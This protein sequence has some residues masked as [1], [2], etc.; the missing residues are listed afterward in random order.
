[1]QGSVVFKGRGGK[2]RH[3]RDVTHRQSPKSSSKKAYESH[4][5]EPIRSGY[6]RSQL[7]TSASQNAS[8]GCSQKSLM[9]QEEK[10]KHQK[11]VKVISV[12]LVPREETVRDGSGRSR[13]MFV[14]KR[15]VWLQPVDLVAIGNFAQ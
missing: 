10:K 5:H 9:V 7:G 15:C 14:A 8:C 1:M 11:E 6:K 12:G 2:I 4:R 3:C 13:I